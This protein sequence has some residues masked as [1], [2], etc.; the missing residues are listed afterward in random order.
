[1]VSEL[2]LKVEVEENLLRYR[3]GGTATDGRIIAKQLNE[4]IENDVYPLILI[5]SSNFPP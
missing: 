5:S 1:L 2:K 3:N 4:V